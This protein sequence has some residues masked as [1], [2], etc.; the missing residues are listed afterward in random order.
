MIVGNGM[1]ANAFKS[2]SAV[3]KGVCI[4]ASGVSNSHCKDMK[5]FNREADLLQQKLASHDEPAAFVYFGTCSVYDPTSQLQP[6]VLHKQ[7]MEKMV[8]MHPF[9]LVIRLPQVAGPNAS[10]YTL[11]AVLCE[12]IRSGRTINVWENATRNIIDVVDMVKIVSSWI[13]VSDQR[14]RVINVANPTSYPIKTIIESVESILGRKGKLNMVSAGAAYEIDIS[15][16]EPLI[17]N[18]EINF[19]KE[20]I[21]RVIARYY[22]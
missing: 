4:F 12:S 21:S 17:N 1:L 14:D 2:Y 20:Y 9:G 11:L 8:Q 19:D 5:E 7:A 6:Y 22:V 3:K 15:E 10:P 16:I 13:F 18:L